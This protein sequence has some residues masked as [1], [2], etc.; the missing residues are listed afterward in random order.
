MKTGKA[1]QADEPATEDERSPNRV[2][3]GTKSLLLLRA[4]DLCDE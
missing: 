3:L 4:A 1:F 2:D